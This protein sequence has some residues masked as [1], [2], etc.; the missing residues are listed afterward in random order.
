MPYLKYGDYSIL[1]QKLA[2]ILALQRDI[3]NRLIYQKQWIR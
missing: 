2:I 3:D 1:I